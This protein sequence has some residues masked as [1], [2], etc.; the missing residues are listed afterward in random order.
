MTN[1]VHHVNLD[2]MA[3]SRAQT[4]VGRTRKDSDPFPMINKALGVLQESGVYA[5]AL[6][7]KSRTGEEEKKIA[8][9]VMDEMLGM[10]HDIGVGLAFGWGQR[11]SVDKPD[12]VLNYLHKNVTSDIE[13]LLLAK[14]SLEQMLIYARYGAKARNAGRANS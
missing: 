14:E 9:A 11:P 6:F 1:E 3:A 13:Q 5:S 2:R 12:E 7:L 8:D 10:L 4:L